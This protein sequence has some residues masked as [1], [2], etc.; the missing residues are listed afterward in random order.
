MSTA[1]DLHCSYCGASQSDVRKLVPG[2]SVLI[3]NECVGRGVVA[4]LGNAARSTGRPESQQG[5]A[6]NPTYCAFCGKQP[7]E[8]KRLVARNG[9]CICDAC[10][11]ASVDILLDGEK[12]SNGAVSF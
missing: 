10:L 9:V 4:L 12:P 3:C 8:V 5:N 2:P 6:P 1:A 7:S 11:V